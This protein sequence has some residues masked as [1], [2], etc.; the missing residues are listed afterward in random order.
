MAPASAVGVVNDDPPPVSEGGTP[1]SRVVTL[2][3]TDEGVLVVGRFTLYVRKNT[4]T[5]PATI[6]MSV[7][8]PEAMEVHFAVSPP[9]ANAFKQSALLT[10]NLSDVADVDYSTETMFRWN[11]DWLELTS[12][13]AHQKQQN[14]DAHIVNLTDCMVGPSTGGKRGKIGTDRLS[15]TGS[16][17][18]SERWAPGLPGPA[19]G[20]PASLVL[21]SRPRP[22]CELRRQR[23]PRQAGHA[24]D[25]R[26]GVKPA[27]AA[28]LNSAP[29]SESTGRPRGEVVGE[30]LLRLRDARG[31]CRNRASRLVSGALTLASPDRHGRR[32]TTPIVRMHP[33]CSRSS[34]RAA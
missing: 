16:P 3:S 10:A 24:Q 34:R 15:G 30:R 31:G 28:E 32:V 33:R 19:P 23:L 1:L 20:L 14:V 29:C 17:G 8:D 18:D 4:L 26:G 21:R 9:E 5:M 7:T 2:T 12:V 27:P 11:R 22:W 6:T 25:P 13:S